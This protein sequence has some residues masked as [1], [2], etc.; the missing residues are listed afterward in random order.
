VTWRCC[1]AAVAKGCEVHSFDP[2]IIVLP[3]GT[4]AG[5]V[6]NLCAVEHR[7]RAA[8]PQVVTSDNMGG[9]VAKCAPNPSPKIHFHE[10]GLYGADINLPG[11]GEV[12]RLSTTMRK[13]GHTHVDI[14]K[15]DVEGGEWAAFGASDGVEM[16]LVASSVSQLTMEVHMMPKDLRSR[17]SA[18]PPGSTPRMPWW[19]WP[20]NYVLVRP[21]MA[22]MNGVLLQLSRHFNVAEAHVNPRSRPVRENL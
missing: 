1:P 18:M 4:D 7:K 6:E 19:P 3:Y 21:Q 11:I 13:L 2:T 10:W 9:A 22:Y 8:M 20:F 12:K 17:L 15:V 16:A 5:Q 14:L